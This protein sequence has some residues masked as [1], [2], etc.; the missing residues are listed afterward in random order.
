HG[1]AGAEVD[2]W[3]GTLSK[4]L[5][6]AGGYIAG[7]SALVAYLKAAT[8]GFIYSVGLPP[9]NTAAAAK[10][11]ELMLREPERVQRLQMNGRHMKSVAIDAGLDTATSSGTAVTPILI[12]D[13]VR[14]AK[15]AERLFSEGINVLP[16]V[17]PAV[18]HDKAI[19]RFFLSSEHN[20]DQIGIAVE[21]TARALESLAGVGRATS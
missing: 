9:G 7:S 14:A 16:I 11:L 2:I 5:A 19:L 10:A 13:S 15:V 20:Q 4:T 12:G 17:Y 3:M 6:S 18:P 8:P 21:A 1:I